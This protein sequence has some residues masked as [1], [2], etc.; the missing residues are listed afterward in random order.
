MI[1]TA[2]KLEDAGYIEKT[3]YN[4]WHGNNVVNNRRKGITLKLQDDKTNI[5]YAAAYLKYI[6]DL[7]KPVYPEIDGR[8][9]IMATLYNIGEYG[10]R[11]KG[12][13]A[14]PESN[15]FGD[16][17]KYNYYKAM[18]LLGIESI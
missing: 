16:Y 2:M 18:G 14:S 17:A 8:T 15:D 3:N 4:E 6:T 13:N 1:S 7:W 12:I 11:E 10:T 5:R 9:A